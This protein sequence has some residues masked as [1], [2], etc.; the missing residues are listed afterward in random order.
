MNVISWQ[1]V[2]GGSSYWKDSCRPGIAVRYQVGCPVCGHR[3]SAETHN[4]E[5]NPYVVAERAVLPW[6]VGQMIGLRN[7]E[8][9]GVRSA[10]PRAQEANLLEALN[11]VLTSERLQEAADAL[12]C[13]RTGITRTMPSPDEREFD[14][15]TFVS[16][17]EGAKME[18]VIE[19]PLLAIDAHPLARH[20]SGAER[21]SVLV[22]VQEATT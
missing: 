1:A 4:A 15:W 14:D 21:G 12:G 5:F 6:L 19:I 22:S 2:V 8:Q 3:Q 13:K 11:L 18:V 9:C 7:C 20:L 17:D 16:S 10:A